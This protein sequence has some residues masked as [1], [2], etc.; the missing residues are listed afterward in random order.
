MIISFQFFFKNNIKSCHSRHINQGVENLRRTNILEIFMD[1]LLEMASKAIQFENISE[2]KLYLCQARRFSKFYHNF[3]CDVGAKAYLASIHNIDEELRILCDKV[4]FPIAPPCLP[5]RISIEPELPEVPSC[6]QANSFNLYEE[7]VPQEEL[8]TSFDKSPALRKS[9]QLNKNAT[10]GSPLMPIHLE[11]I[12]A[13]WKPAASYENANLAGSRKSIKFKEKVIAVQ[14]GDSN[15]IQKPQG[16]SPISIL[17][18]LDKPF[19]DNSVAN[20]DSKKEEVRNKSSDKSHSMVSYL[21]GK[22]ESS[23]KLISTSSLSLSQN[24]NQF[25]H[26]LTHEDHKAQIRE[27]LKRKTLQLKG[28]FNQSSDS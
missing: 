15:P 10:E 1:H 26:N 6:R 21:G 28:A 4:D 20:G 8:D 2:A 25:L 17:R 7:M 16:Y 13:C 3:G 12:K 23:K 5:R 27:M 18:S 19:E 9:L 24:T 22:L 14:E 11:E